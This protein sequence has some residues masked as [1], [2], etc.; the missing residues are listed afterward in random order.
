MEDDLP[1]PCALDPERAAP[2]SSRGVFGALAGTVAHQRPILAPSDD[3]EVCQH[4]PAQRGTLECGQHFG[5]GIRPPAGADLIEIFGDVLSQVLRATLARH[6]HDPN[7]KLAE[8]IGKWRHGY[9]WI[10]FASSER[11]TVI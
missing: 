8:F 9:D 6:S 2:G 11:F 10:Y 1:L 7:L 3:P 5:F 4:E